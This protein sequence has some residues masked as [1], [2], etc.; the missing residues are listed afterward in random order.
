MVSFH[1]GLVS[2]AM[3]ELL[4]SQILKLPYNFQLFSMTCLLS[5]WPIPFLLQ[6]E[7]QRKSL[8]KDLDEREKRH[9]SLLHCHALL[10]EEYTSYV[11]EALLSFCL[12]FEKTKLFIKKMGKRVN[13]IY[14]W[15]CQKEKI[16]EQKTV[17]ALASLISH[18]FL[19]MR[20]TSSR[21]LRFTYA[22]LPSTFYHL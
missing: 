15:S 3:E 22:S 17:Q 21:G 16:V 4:S 6:K 13:F 19:L 18:L 14:F 11:Q 12:T 9:F 2:R 10:L 7:E 1:H 8:S 5:N 20:Q